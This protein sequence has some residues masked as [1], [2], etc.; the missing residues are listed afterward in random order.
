LNQFIVDL[1]LWAMIRYSGLLAY[2]LLFIGMALGILYS[3][4]QWTS[5]VKMKVMKGHTLANNTGTLLALFHAVLL[6]IDTYM[7]FSW[8]EILVPFAA[9]KSPVANGL[10]TLAV[11]GLLILLLTTDLRNK[12][13]RKL[14]RMIHLL[15]YPIFIMAL[16]HGFFVGSDS[17]NGLVRNMYMMT[18][19][20]LLLLTVAR[21]LVPSRKNVPRVR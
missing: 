6:I 3:F 14:W 19:L 16:L 4:P 11:Y 12:L 10:G 9:E 13:K 2:L 7:P 18:S 21:F 20:V 8:R 1:P 17:G 5:S 15:S